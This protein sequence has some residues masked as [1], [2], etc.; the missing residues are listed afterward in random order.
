MK[1][2]VDECTGPSVAGW[3]INV[4]H[5]VYSVYELSRGLSDESVLEIA[6]KDGRVLITNDRDFGEMIFRLKMQHCGVIFLRLLD[7][8]PQGKIEVLKK[9]M[10]NHSDIIEGNFI[11][12]T[13]KRIRVA[14]P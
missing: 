4:G 9:I 7:N 6:R 5:D 11:T 3:L 8:S 12:A 2:I 13:E 14:K 10:D 1:F